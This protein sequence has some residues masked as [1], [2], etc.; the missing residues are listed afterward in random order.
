MSQCR[1]RK[2]GTHPWTVGPIGVWRLAS[3][4][5]VMGC[6]SSTAI[7]KSTSSSH[8]CCLRQRLGGAQVRDNNRTYGFARP[9]GLEGTTCYW[10][11]AWWSESQRVHPR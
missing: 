9:C 1:K 6:T 2:T 11:E 8:T 7:K 5:H 3:T 4:N 10:K